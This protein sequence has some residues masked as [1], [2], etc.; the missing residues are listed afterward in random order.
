MRNSDRDELNTY[1]NRKA[2]YERRA[3]LAD[4]QQEQ[5]AKDIT[6]RDQEFY[7][8]T[9]EH[10]EEAMGNAPF[11]DRLTVFIAIGAAIDSNLDNEYSNHLVCTA[12]QQLVENYWLGCA[13][14]HWKQENKHG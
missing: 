4:Q 3:E 7:P 8:W 6:Q 13:K 1:L 9:Q 14:Y 11:G 5:Y 12:I 2:E 10:F